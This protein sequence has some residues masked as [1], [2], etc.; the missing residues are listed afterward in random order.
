MTQI[1]ATFDIK[2]KKKEKNNPSRNIVYILYQ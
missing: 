1:S 2:K